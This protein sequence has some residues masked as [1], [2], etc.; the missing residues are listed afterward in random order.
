MPLREVIY[1]PVFPRISLQAFLS[2]AWF[3]DS[4]YQKKVNFM[5]SSIYED[6]EALMKKAKVKKQ[7]SELATWPESHSCSVM[8]SGRDCCRW[9]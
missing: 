4:Q 9:K 2:L 7:T 5:S 1:E 8:V 6:K 3:A